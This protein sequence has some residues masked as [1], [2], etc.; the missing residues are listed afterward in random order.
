MTYSEMMKS[1]CALLFLHR[2][3]VSI[4]FFKKNLI[5]NF[6]ISGKE[7]RQTSGKEAALP[8]PI[9]M[10]FCSMSVLFS[11]DVIQGPLGYEP[12]CS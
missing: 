6:E 7:I 8:I 11:K 10:Y 5:Q 1:F 12:F 4:F 2:A 3:L 9:Q